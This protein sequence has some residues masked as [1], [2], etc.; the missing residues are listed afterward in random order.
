MP[1]TEELTAVYCTESN[2]TDWDRFVQHCDGDIQQTSAWTS[3]YS[4]EGM[5]VLRFYLLDRATILAGAQIVKHK[6]PFLGQIGVIQQGPC[7]KSDSEESHDLFC[8]ETVKIA[9]LEKLKYIAVVQNYNTQNS[10]NSLR[11]HGFNPK[12]GHLP[13]NPTVKSTWILEL[14]RPVDAIFANMKKGRRKSIQKGLT[15]PIVHKLGDRND[16]NTFFELMLETCK[17]RNAKPIINS[18]DTFYKVWDSLSPNKLIVLHLGLVDNKVVCA[19]LG[20]TCGKTYKNWFWGWNGEY[21]HYNISDTIEWKIIEWAKREGFR[22][23]DFVHVDPISAE[24]IESDQPIAP[25]IKDRSHFGSTFYKMQFGGHI[26]HY[27]DI[28]YY[29]PSKVNY[30][31]FHVLGK[32]VFGSERF[33]VFII[34]LIKKVKKS[35]QKAHSIGTTLYLLPEHSFQLIE[36][37]II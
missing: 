29:Y 19:S 3:I 32:W 9:S 10:T 22:Y 35:T 34:G 36:A 21:A 4:D 11:R 8:Q 17:R 23:Y 12:P 20:L 26:V 33:R 16:L 37:G 5:E 28:Y 30:F 27:P 14:S 13:P 6:I 7:V 24:A 18:V 1:L 31:I 2:N 25:E 15:F